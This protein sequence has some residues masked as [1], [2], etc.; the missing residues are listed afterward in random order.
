MTQGI[1]TVPTP[2]NE[3]VR[4]YGLNSKDR[5]EIEKELAILYNK[6]IDIPLYIAGERI[7]EGKKQKAIVPHD[8]KHVLGYFHQ[9]EKEHVEMAISA[10]MNAKKAWADT[11]WQD[12][13]AIFL[14]AAE[15]L[16]DKYRYKLNAAAMLDLSKNV[17]QAEI[18]VICELADFFR[19]NAKY[20]E[21][22]MSSQPYSPKGQWNRTDTRPLDGFVF[23]VTPFNFAS[24]AGNLPSAPALMG[25]TVVWKPASSAVYTAHFIMEIF[26]EAGL[27]K[28]VINMIPGKGSIVGPMVIENKYL[29]GIHFTGSTGVFNSMWKTI[30]E[31][32]DNYITYPRIV[33]ETGG[34][35]FIFAHN[36]CDVEAL[37]TAS[38]R[39]A[40]EYQG[41]KC[42]AASRIFVPKSIYPKYEELLLEEMKSVKMGDVKSFGNFVNAVIDESAFNTI[43]SYVDYAKDNKDIDIIFGGDCDSSEGFFIEPTILLCKNPNVRTLKEEIFGPVLSIYVYE[44]KDLDQALKICDE[45]SIYGLTGAVFSQDRNM[46]I[47]ISNALRGT[48][49]NFYIND[50][51]TGAVV[52]QQPFG[53]SRASGTNDKAGSIL[54]LFRWTTPRTIKETFNP[55]TDYRYPFLEE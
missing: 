53:G 45:A 50:K 13:A 22:I 20:L 28:G 16:T 9:A 37:V 12:R 40:F 6:K 42:S 46:I 3:R 17:Y 23:A 27:P 8:N 49:G 44:D 11:P 51:P 26:I 10:A 5:E 55:P 35:D 32:I 41:Q 52:G 54:N 33:G 34:K 21:E 36:S 25:N 24:I 38:I 19:F 14:K 4:E 30:G 47:K 18:D 2:Y 31:R 43:K 39:G 29:S 48:A 7:Y 1:F 15:L